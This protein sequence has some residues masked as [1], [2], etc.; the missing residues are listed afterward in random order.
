MYM[1]AHII[2]YP[3]YADISEHW[4]V[5][6]LYAGLADT[7]IFRPGQY[8]YIPARPNLGQSTQSQPLSSY[9]SSL[10]TLPGVIPRQG[11][12]PIEF[13]HVNKGG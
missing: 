2:M 6:G 9:L 8:S 1:P 7:P 4:P 3:S 11:E 10:L 13:V 5:Y 12:R